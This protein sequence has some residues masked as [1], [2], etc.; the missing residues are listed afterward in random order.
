[1][2][3]G[4]HQ[5]LSKSKAKFFIRVTRWAAQHKAAS[6][7]NWISASSQLL[8]G[9]KR[10]SASPAALP[11]R[12][13]VYHHSRTFRCSEL[14]VSESTSAKRPVNWYHMPAK[15]NKA[16]KRNG[17]LRELCRKKHVIDRAL[18]SNLAS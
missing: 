6:F 15:K 3:T 9:E 11:A 13:A 17:G 1:M 4:N 18:K 10:L 8:S 5:N 2:L 12:K 7:E 16:S 14:Q